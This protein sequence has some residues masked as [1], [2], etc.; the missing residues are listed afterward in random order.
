MADPTL[1]RR[2]GSLLMHSSIAAALELRPVVTGEA[3][4]ADGSISV[5]DV[6][7]AFVQ[8]NGEL[9]PVT[10]DVCDGMTL[11]TE[12]GIRPDGKPGRG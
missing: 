8:W 9:R 6:C 1:D 2:D 4:L 5:Y 7:E 11:L 10:V 3:V 12:A